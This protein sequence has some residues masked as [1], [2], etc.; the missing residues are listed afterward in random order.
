MCK[1][2]NVIIEIIEGGENKRTYVIRE[3][4]PNSAPQTLAVCDTADEVAQ[5][6]DALAI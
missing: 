4:V 6:L 5:F 3:L 2:K 1:V